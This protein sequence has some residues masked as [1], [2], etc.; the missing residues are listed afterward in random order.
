MF[1]IE[2]QPNNSPIDKTN[3]NT[4]QLYYSTEESIEFK[5]LCKIGMIKMYPNTFAEANINDF[6]LVLLRRY[7]DNIFKP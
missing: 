4:I 6:L 2:L 5:Q 3:I 1:E 7:N